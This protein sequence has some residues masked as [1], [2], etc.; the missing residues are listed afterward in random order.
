MR[1]PGR[2]APRR[3]PAALALVSLVAVLSLVL[4]GL[5]ALV[6]PPAQASP[7]RDDY[8]AYLKARARDALVDPWNF[9]S[10]ECTSFVAWRLTNDNGVGD[11][12]NRYLGHHWGDA[13]IWKR[14]AL[15]SGVAVNDQP[16]VGAVAW[17]SASSTSGGLG[18]VAWVFQSSDSS[19]TIEEYNY[20]HYGGYDQRT[21]TRGSRYWPDGFIHVRDLELDSTSRPT[22]S[23]TARVGEIMAGHRG[24]WTSTPTSYSYQWSADGR[25]ISW[26]TH[27]KFRPRP[28]QL[29][30]QITVTVTATAAGLDPARAT[31]AAT[32]AVA[33]GEFADTAEPV[34]GGTAQVGE[35]VSVTPGTWSPSTGND[36]AYQWYADGRAIRGATDAAYAPTASTVGKT[37]TARVTVSRP[38][39]DDAVVTTAAT[40]PVQPGRFDETLP[41]TI[42]GKPQVDRVLTVA[43]GTWDPGTG[44]R[45]HYQWLADGV[46]VAGATGSSL[47]LGPDLVGR[48]ITAQVTVSRSG[49][50]DATA[51]TDPTAAVAPGIFRISR[52]PSATGTPQVA[53]QLRGH[54]G[55]WSPA[56]E[57]T[58]QW[59][60]DGQPIPGATAL[61]HNPKPAE[62]GATLSL[63][64]T[65]AAPGYATETRVWTAS[66]PV[67]P[68]EFA[69][70][71]RPTV[72][73]GRMV[74]DRLR[75]DPGS[76]SL[77]DVALSYQWRADGVPIAGAADAPTYRLTRADAGHR[78]S[79]RVT[80]SADGYRSERAY[81]H[82]GPAVRLGDAAFLGSP[83]VTG[84][85]V[86]GRVL[87][88][89]VGDRRPA[90][91]RPIYQWYRGRTA[92]AGATH[93]RYRIQPAD[94]GRRLSVRIE[95]APQDW[96][97]AV[98][99]TD[100]T[101][102]VRDR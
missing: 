8:P 21:I 2:V 23:G 73:G 79:V 45:Y 1:F 6:G 51:V 17:W 87:T 100:R 47:E 27:R 52:P 20:L 71:A 44:N 30:K 9:Y 64:I 34:V 29:G 49:Y 83:H 48:Q 40:A 84:R 42:S 13:G 4:A 18:H 67:L 69:S 80:A 90:R 55:A 91:T 72:Q 81:S 53:E 76:W 10:R 32:S 36:Y 95:L 63:A 15:A 92:I 78:I 7:G 41:P 66:A 19:I 14:A 16:A 101:D 62:V 37:L 12:T 59:L 77:P 74:G 3:A 33:P 93:R 43:P 98:W 11:F 60:A 28:A 85:T 94:G 97:H 58:Y 56:P 24:S 88:A 54:R 70:L 75:A 22:V 50:D 61:R 68:G 96:T 35:E 57:F 46:P 38:A 86:V 102:V 5:T 89:R 26:A 31:S 82:R 65:G 99:R 39:Y 25:E